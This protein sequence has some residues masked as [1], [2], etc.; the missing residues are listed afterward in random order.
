[1]RLISQETESKANLKQFFMLVDCLHPDLVPTEKSMVAHTPLGT[2]GKLLGLRYRVAINILDVIVLPTDE[3][4][5][6]P[7]GPVGAPASSGQGPF[8]WGGQHAGKSSAPGRPAS[9]AGS[10][11]SEARGRAF[12]SGLI[13][14]GHVAVFGSPV[15]P[16]PAAPRLAS[17]PT[18]G[19]QGIHAPAL[20]PIRRAAVW[21][22]AAALPFFPSTTGR[23]SLVGGTSSGLRCGSDDGTS[24]RPVALVERGSPVRTVEPQSSCVL[25]L[26]PTDLAAVVGEGMGLHLSWFDLMSWRW[27]HVGVRSLTTSR[28]PFCQSLRSSHGTF[29][30]AC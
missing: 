6:L 7:S 16:L 15:S 20:L 5:P 21:P 18:W 24:L 14:C 9:G 12:S 4:P 1:V 17:F 25:S 3:E 19:L 30:P 13:G 22:S 2:S 29:Q 27:P 11:N 28:G 26:S 23:L 8:D 10:A